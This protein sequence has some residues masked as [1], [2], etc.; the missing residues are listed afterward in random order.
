MALTIAWEGKGVIAECDDL[1]DSAGGTWTEVGG[2]FIEQGVDSYL[3]GSSCIAGAYS[4]KSG[5]QRYTLGTGLGPLDFDTGGA[6]EGQFIY[7]WI[8]QSTVYLNETIANGGMRITL[9]T[10][11]SNYR[12][13]IIAAGDDTNGWT[14]DWRCFIIDPTKPGSINDTGTY[15]PG[16]ITIINVWVDITALAKGNNLLI[17]QISVGKGLR[18]TGTS[19]NLWGDV[20]DY[21]TDRANRAWGCVQEREGLYYFYGK[22]F[23]GDSAVAANQS[24]VDTSGP[25]IKFGTCE[26]YYGGGWVL[27]H[28]SDYAGIEIIDTASYTTTFDDG[29]IVGSDGGRDGTTWI[30][31]EDLE[32]YMDFFGGNHAGSLTRLYG[33]QFRDILGGIN[34][35]DDA[36]HLFYG[37]SVTGCAQFDPVGAPI[38]RNVNFV[39]TASP[40]AALLWNEDIN[41]QYCNFIANTIGAAI[42]HRDYIGSPYDYY[43]L[44][45]SGND[46]DVLNSSGSY[47]T[48]TTTTT[49]AP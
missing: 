3:V 31:H 9:M 23:L 6:E 49:T 15:D 32:V 20:V 21:C 46:C 8:Q 7:I 39:S 43:Y 45:F 41:I 25:I 22:M 12:D 38:I 17:D 37:G 44:T 18:I 26:Y 16:N 42:E 36:Q 11:T 33:T 24:F 28:P 48:T 19:T 30:G 27:S 34:M 1:T 4:N 35:G 10:D 14:G 5:Y 29:V 13:Y 40:L 47:T 2:G